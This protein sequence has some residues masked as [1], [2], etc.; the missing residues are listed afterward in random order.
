MLAFRAHNSALGSSSRDLFHWPRS[1]PKLRAILLLLACLWGLASTAHGAEE[2]VRFT[3]ESEEN[4]LVIDLNT[5]AITYTN[6]VVIRSG[7]AALS[8]RRAKWDEKSGQ[9]MAAGS[10]RLQQDNEVWYGERIEYN[11]KT[12]KI[13]ATDF[14]AGQPPFFIKGAALT[15]DQQ[16]EVYVLAEGVV[17]TD[18]YAEPGYRIRAKSLTIAPGDYIE[19]E[20]AVL[21]L[22]DTPVFWFPKWRRSL[23]QHPNFWV[24]TP[25]YR[26]KYGPYLLSTYEWYWNERLSGALHVDGRLE[27]GVGVGPDFRYNLPSFGKGELKYYYTHDEDTE[28]DNNGVPIDKDRQRFW[29]EHEGTLRTNLTLKSAVRYQSD[30]QIVRDFFESEYHENTQPSTFLEL[31]QLWSNWSLNLLAQPRVNEF[32][33]TVERL[34][35]LK[36]TGLRQQIGRTPLFYDSESSAGYYQR[37]FAT[38]DTNALEYIDTNHFAA[39]R[40]D[41]YHQVTLP[42]TLFGWL[43]VTPRAGGR[44][45]YYGEAHGPGGTTMEDQR[46]VFN[47]G[48]E[49]SFKA[50]RTWEGTRSPFWEIDGVR[51]IVQPSANYVYVPRPDVRPAD[52]PQFDYELQSAQLLP[53]HYPDYNSIDSIDSQNV[54]RFGL[55]NKLQTKRREGVENF[56]HWSLYTDWRLRPRSGQDTFADVYSKLDVKPFS[57]LTLNSELN[58]NI[59]QVEWD[60]VNHAVTF[61]PNDTWSW[62]VGQRYLRDGAFYGTN[63]GSSLV[64]SSLYLRLSP[65][66]AARALHYY[67]ERERQLQ[68]QSYTIYRDFRSWTVALTFRLIK[69]RGS[70]DD[71]GVAVTFS[72]KALPRYQLGDDVNKPSLLLGY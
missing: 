4:S 48:A 20:D 50:S 51:H 43:N 54:I 23:K 36:L 52:L 7:N 31:N 53:L 24:F 39:L 3:I 21:Y 68:R 58:Y 47:T 42:W 64:F 1:M 15:G 17:T 11:F 19:A 57:W 29:F 34:P 33:E 49:V 8:A 61:T 63:A 44:F 59:N 30:S 46:T 26:S 56:V 72:S 28:P 18:D 60:Q 6:G 32:Q 66:W 22:K 25:G 2:P 67:D 16:A 35:D 38:V 41:T 55:E 9:V 70:K 5:G 13:L 69:D 45:T 14:K 65:N 37:R 40:A 12:R 10:V 71:F 27:R 62:T